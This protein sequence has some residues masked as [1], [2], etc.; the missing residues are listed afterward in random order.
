M[1]NSIIDCER[2]FANP[3][4]ECMSKVA[5]EG[6]DSRNGY[7]EFGRDNS[8]SGDL[9][10]LENDMQYKRG[11]MKTVKPPKRLS[12]KEGTKKGRLASN[13]TIKSEQNC[14]QGLPN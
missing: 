10:V 9:R 14:N 4:N 12:M 6:P 3:Y 8:L 2:A 5:K 1:R 7:T 11:L 13:M